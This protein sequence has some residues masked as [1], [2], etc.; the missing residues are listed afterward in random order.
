MKTIRL[1]PALL[2][3]LTVIAVTL[4]LMVL[5]Q[6]DIPIPTAEVEAGAVD[7]DGDGIPDDADVCPNAMG[8]AANSGCP[9]LGAGGG[10]EEMV[11]TEEA[12][13][14]VTEEAPAPIVVEPEVTE[15]PPAATPEV[16]DDTTGEDTTGE[17]TTG[18]D[19]TGEDTTGEDTTETISLDRDNDGYLDD[20][21]QCPDQYGERNNGCPTPTAG[22]DTTGEDTTGDDTTGED[23]TGEDTTGDDTTG[24]TPSDDDFDGDGVPND[25]DACP[26]TFSAATD[27]AGCPPEALGQ[28]PG[29][30]DP[31][32]DGIINAIDACDDEAG[33]IMNVGCPEGQTGDQGGGDDD[34][35]A[36]SDGDTGESVSPVVSEPVDG[37]CPGSLPTRLEVGDTGEIVDLF[38]TLRRTPDGEEIRRVDG[39][40]TF[41]V[42]DGPVCFNTLT[43]FEIEYPDGD[44]GWALESQRFSIYGLDQYWLAPEAD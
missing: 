42:I 14:D 43:W 9:Q 26:S 4:P 15:E 40:A 12:P 23:T 8:D 18:E 5:A 33:D 2:I 28:G 30:E 24:P 3:V 41:E 37:D 34:D 38:S 29:S 32:G 17:D 35:D 31:D 10:A 21:D 27:T 44:S 11:A 25:Q 20:F 13:M 7:T 16:G 1:F 36:A 22:E 39:P 6:D 19:T